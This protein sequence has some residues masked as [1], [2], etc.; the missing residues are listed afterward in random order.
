[1]EELQRL[2]DKYRTPLVLSYLQ[3]LS[4]REIAEQLGCPLGTVFTRL[5]RGRD[6][7]RKR[8]TRRGVTLSAGLLSAALTAGAATPALRA[9]V[10][11]A[12]AEVAVVFA[13]GAGPAAGVIS[14]NVVA[15][16]EGVLKMTGP[17]RLR[18]VCAA[19]LLLAVAGSGAGLLALR[20]TAREQEVA[21]KETGEAGKPA[22]AARRPP[23][24]ALRYGGK[25]FDEW[26]S[27]L[28]TDL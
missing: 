19:L 8:L 18:I 6:L 20:G 10:G 15:L 2:P 11:R 27:V 26:R 7:L 13:A 12:T 28:R 14:P 21:G 22:E 17:S 9:G 25:D 24:E 23:K 4:N 5:A 1:D 3:G 16:T